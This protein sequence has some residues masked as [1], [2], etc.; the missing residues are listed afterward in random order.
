M[1]EKE[2]I[3]AAIAESLHVVKSDALTIG[4]SSRTA[5]RV[6][7]LAL[8]GSAIH[9]GVQSWQN[10]EEGAIVINRATL[11]VTTPA[12]AAGTVEIG[13]T[14]TSAATASANLIDTLDVHTA[15][16]AFDNLA[17]PGTNGKKLQRLATGDWVTIGQASGDTT[18]MVATLYLEYF[19][20]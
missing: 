16:G 11:D 8:T 6:A 19:L 12:T 2:R 3:G 7:R 18:G 5:K 1:A 14:A 4:D 10:P 15:A 13:T 17:N 9:G 20:V